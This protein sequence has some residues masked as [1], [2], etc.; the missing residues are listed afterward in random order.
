MTR[1]GAND[2]EE[3]NLNRRCFWGYRMTG[4]LSRSPSGE[5]S[6]R[7][8]PADPAGDRQKTF[9][10]ASS[11]I[12]ATTLSLLLQCLSEARYA[13]QGHLTAVTGFQPQSFRT[14]IPSPS[15]DV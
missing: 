3:W 7:P 11:W 2:G 5:I 12:M 4:G 15:G 1:Y 13:S 10:T 8:R 14:D 6:P 9:R